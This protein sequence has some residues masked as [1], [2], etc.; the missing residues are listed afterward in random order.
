MRWGSA[1]VKL[2]DENRAK[3][4]FTVLEAGGLDLEVPAKLANAV[5]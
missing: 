2:V 1:P 4:L 5:G 3:R